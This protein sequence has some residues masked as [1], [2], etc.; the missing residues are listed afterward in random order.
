MSIISTEWLSLRPFL[1]KDV[2]GVLSYLRNPRI[3]CFKDQQ[4]SA[5]ED[6]CVYVVLKK[7]WSK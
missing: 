6:T 1:K 2:A 5:T 3:I 4:L 7:E